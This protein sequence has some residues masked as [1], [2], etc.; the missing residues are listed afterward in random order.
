MT[1][2]IYWTKPTHWEARLYTAHIDDLTHELVALAW[3][4][5]DHDY[6]DEPI[7]SYW[8]GDNGG[9]FIGEIHVYDGGL[10]TMDTR[11][12]PQINRVV[13][14]VSWPTSVPN[15]SLT[16]TAIDPALA[17]L[18]EA[19]RDSWDWGWD[20]ATVPY[21]PS[22][23]YPDMWGIDVFDGQGMHLDWLPGGRWDDGG[24]THGEVVALAADRGYHLAE[25]LSD[26]VPVHAHVYRV[27]DIG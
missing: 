19:A 26:D 2:K 12:W 17:A 11:Q 4:R 25:L 16:P 9:F 10:S 6:T 18:D 14:R 27:V 24:P 22:D 5:A 21:A 8:L 13:P 1:N 3:D 23:G 15:G 20:T 7:A